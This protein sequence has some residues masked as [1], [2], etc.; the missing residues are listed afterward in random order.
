MFQ[1]IPSIFFN[2]WHTESCAAI[3]LEGHSYC[4]FE[5]GPKITPFSAVRCTFTL[6]T[7]VTVLLNLD[8]R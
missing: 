7:S 2:W 1:T 3:L 5:F 4:T 8:L 6:S